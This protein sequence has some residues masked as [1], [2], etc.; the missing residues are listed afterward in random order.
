MKSAKNNEDRAWILFAYI[1]PIFTGLAVYLLFAH[2]SK[3]LRFHS[4]Q[5]VLYGIAMLI[6]YSLFIWMPFFGFFIPFVMLF[7]WLYGMYIG[8]SGYL[9]ST[10]HIPVIGEIAKKA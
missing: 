10:L 6:V 7:A 8:Y 2:R 3:E 5:S 1:I 4:V 9:G